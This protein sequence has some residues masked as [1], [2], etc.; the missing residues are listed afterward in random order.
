MPPKG[1]DTPPASPCRDLV[2]ALSVASMD[3][4]QTSGGG[5]TTASPSASADAGDGRTNQSDSATPP[6]GGSATATSNDQSN[7][8]GGDSILAGPIHAAG[9]SRRDRI[10][11][12]RHHHRVSLSFADESDGLGEEEIYVGHSHHRP[13]PPRSAGAGLEME[14]GFRR[15]NTS[16]G[17]IDDGD[18]GDD[19]DDD[20]DGGDDRKPSANAGAA[21]TT[22]AATQSSMSKK[23]PTPPLPPPTPISG[24]PAHFVSPPPS[25]Q[26]AQPRRSSIRRPSVV[27]PDTDLCADQPPSTEK[28]PKM[29]RNNLSFQSLEVREY[30]Q[31]LGDHP[32]CQ[33]GLPLSLGWDY[34][35]DATIH[36][37][38][39]YET[40]RESQRVKSRKDMKLDCEE[41]R[42]ILSS[43]TQ[44]VVTETTADG[45]VL[46]TEE[47]T[48]YTSMDLRRAERRLYRERR[49]S[50]RKMDSFFGSAS[51]NGDDIADGS[52]DS[53]NGADHQPAQSASATNVAPMSGKQR[54]RSFFTSS[55]EEI[56]GISPHHE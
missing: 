12:R 48:A 30:S 26:C 34:D 40:H 5:S 38:D 46:A 16:T 29:R 19:E 24:L 36:D 42:E 28:K 15:S 41:R 25:A 55:Q 3:Q 39:E 27:S 17:S 51:G 13:Q 43:V 11:R 7:A 44:R 4:Q 56:T 53:I 37:V 9:G 47:T 32:C 22:D 35:A 21:A 18:D 23:R 10:R 14:V 45:A 6:I 50:S 8:S 52:A 1:H 33:S 20:S 31:V 54:R 49:V 2:L